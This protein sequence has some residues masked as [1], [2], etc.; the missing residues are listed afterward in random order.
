MKQAEIVDEPGFGGELKSDGLMVHGS[1]VM[2]ERMM[3]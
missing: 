1:M 3:G 2:M